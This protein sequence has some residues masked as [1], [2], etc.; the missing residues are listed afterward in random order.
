MTTTASIPET[1]EARALALYRERGAEIQRTAP[2]TYNVPSCSGEGFYVVDYR[3]ERCDCPDFERRGVA[4]K[5]VYAVGIH[6][7]KRH[8]KRRGESL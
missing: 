6:R 1:R 8:T 3:T 7:S 2:F 4:C 5:H